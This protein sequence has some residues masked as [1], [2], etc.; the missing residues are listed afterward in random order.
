MTAVSGNMGDYQS[1]HNFFTDLQNSWTGQ[2]E[3]VA[4]DFTVSATYA[5]GVL[6]IAD[7]LQS[8]WLTI[9][10]EVQNN[11]NNP[12]AVKNNFTTMLTAYGA[13][14]TWQS[15]GIFLQ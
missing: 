14:R 4:N 9:P 15:N 7:G 6:N 12:Q 10:Q 13:A 8:G 5:A 11:W 1:T 3:A 2:L